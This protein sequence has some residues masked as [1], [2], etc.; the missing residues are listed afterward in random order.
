MIKAFISTI[1]LVVAAYGGEPISPKEAEAYLT[2]LNCIFSAYSVYTGKDASISGLG[3]L[4]SGQAFSN[5]VCANS[6]EEG[7]AKKHEF[8]WLRVVDLKNGQYRGPG[9]YGS[10]WR[11]ES[12]PCGTKS[13]R[14]ILNANR[15][16]FNF[17]K[18]KEWKIA[19][20]KLSAIPDF[21]KLLDGTVEKEEFE[22]LKYGKFRWLYWAPTKD[23]T[24]M[25]G[26][27]DKNLEDA[28]D[29]ASVVSQTDS[30]LT[31]KV[32]KEKWLYFTSKDQCQMENKKS[33]KPTKSDKE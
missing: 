3:S 29:P 7:G 16:E 23:C 28:Q 1:L 5:A 26:N 30:K 19:S 27:A 12:G 10:R 8:C 33:L 13:L 25:P 20:D 15:S 24:E 6:Y 2:K 32:G 11:D 17:G 18:D 31:L 21:K 22:K 14:K 4:K 9:G